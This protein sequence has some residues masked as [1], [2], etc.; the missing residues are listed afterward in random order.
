MKKQMVLPVA[1][2]LLATISCIWPIRSGPARATEVAFGYEKG[3][4]DAEATFQAELTQQALY[5][6]TPGTAEPDVTPTCNPSLSNLYC[7][8]ETVNAPYDDTYTGLP[9]KTAVPTPSG[10]VLFSVK[11]KG[12]GAWTPNN[13]YLEAGSS[14]QYS[15]GFSSGYSVQ[16][17]Y[18]VTLP[19]YE[20][21][22]I[23]RYYLVMV[24]VWV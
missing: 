9:T 14:Y 19:V 12:G 20:A 17:T 18:G 4:N 22:L 21:Y 2:V 16:L 13:L 15:T 1:L 5:P 8:A 7:M 24:E 3:F 23:D 11:T 6:P 10:P